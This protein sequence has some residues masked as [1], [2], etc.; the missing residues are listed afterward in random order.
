M[1]LLGNGLCR[2]QRGSSGTFTSQFGLSLSAC[3]EACRNRPGCLAVEYSDSTRGC[4]LHTE[5]I[6]G[7]E[8]LQRPF[9]CWTKEEGLSL[10][11]QPQVILE[12]T[13]LQCP[14]RQMAEAL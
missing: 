9:S 14:F 7:V 13:K 1:V 8:N 6:T 5:L 10:P 3:Q 11:L 12:T 4:E 2:T